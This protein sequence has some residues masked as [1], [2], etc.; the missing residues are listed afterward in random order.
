MD[1]LSVVIPVKNEEAE[2]M[3]CLESVKWADEII[4]V[5][6]YSTDR[7][8]EICRKYTDKIFQKKLEGFSAQREFGLS[9]AAGT[10]IL[11]LDADEVVT[12]PLQ[13]EIK[14]VLKNG[15]E[16]D[17][18]LISRP[19]NYLGREI[20]YCGWALKILV[21]FRKEKSRYDGKLVHESIIVDGR[22]GHFKNKII[23]KGYKN[24][25]EYFI[26]M[27]LYTSLDA[28]D[29]RRNGVRLNALNYPV[30]L[31][32]KPVF[33]FFR[34]YIFMRGFMDGVRG[35]FISVIAAF[36]VFMNYAKLWEIQKNA[37]DRRN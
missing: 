9:K 18:F 1:R 3:E 4:I 33:I 31:F 6:D 2:I 7:T 25:S 11:H 27:D 16:Y 24:L 19:T 35:F 20:R 5:D 15:T 30:Y 13:E 17:G 22:I 12:P 36:V 8:I 23:H 21:F 10:W 29:M 34:K 14:A 32:M 28:E 26:K 37:A